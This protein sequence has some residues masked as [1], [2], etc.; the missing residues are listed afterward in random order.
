M[1]HTHVVVLA[2]IAA[3]VFLSACGGSGV[4]GPNPSPVVTPPP[5]TIGPAPVGPMPTSVTITV[6]MVTPP[7]GST[8]HYGAGD[9]ID[10]KYEIVGGDSTSCWALGSCLSINNSSC[11]SQSLQRTEGPLHLPS[12]EF[13]AGPQV[14]SGGSS[15]GTFATHSAIITIQPCDDGFVPSSRAIQRVIVPVD[16]TWAP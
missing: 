4:S 16:W 2:A 13:S 11:A 5:A 10:L 6:T 7:S 14:P 3:M 8:I 15:Q 9:R 1:R 12:G